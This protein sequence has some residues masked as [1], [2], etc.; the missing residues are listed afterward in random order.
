MGYEFDHKATKLS[1]L[2][3]YEER[4]NSQIDLVVTCTA[5]C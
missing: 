2:S 4:N 3:Q 1:F 5:D